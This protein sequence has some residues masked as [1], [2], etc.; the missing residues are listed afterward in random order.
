MFNTTVCL[1]SLY[2]TATW[3]HS[4]WVFT[5]GTAPNARGS[6][7]RCQDVGIWK[8]LQT[9]RQS[10]HTQRQSLN[11]QRQPLNTQREPQSE[12]VEYSSRWV[13]ESSIRVGHRPIHLWN[14]HGQREPQLDGTQC[15]LYSTSSCWVL[16]WVIVICVGSIG[17]SRWVREAF[18]VP[19]CWYFQYEMVALGV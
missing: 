6:C 14:L 11:T 2:S 10:L 17:D 3:N 15:D 8:A 13:R 5:F 19:T 18:S 1:I 16:R 4:R 7:C 9:Q 12:P